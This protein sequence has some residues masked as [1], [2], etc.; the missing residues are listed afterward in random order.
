MK[1][2]EMSKVVLEN[3]GGLENIKFVERCATRLRIHFFKKSKVDLE[4]I[5]KAEGVMGVVEKG[6]QIQLIIGPTV[7]EAYTDFLEVSGFKLSGNESPVSDDN[8]EEEKNFSYY[9]NAFGSFAAGVFMPIIP[10]LVTGGLILSI[11]N[12]LVNYMGFGVDSGTAQIM[13]AIFSAGFSMLP[14]WIGYTLSSKLKM[15]PIMGAFLGAVLVSGS[16][17]GVEGLDFFGISVPAVAYESSVMPIV[18]GVVFMYFVNKLLV[19]IIPDMV[20]FFLK[21]LLT[22]AIVVPV[23]LIVLGPIGTEL[24]GAVGNFME[25]FMGV[26]GWLAVPVIA[27][28]YPYMVMLGL[29]KAITVIMIESIATTGADNW[30]LV[31]GLVSNLC[32]GAA[33]L[34]VALHVRDR[35]QKGL[36]ASFGVTALCG[37][38]EP[39][40]YGSLIM[41]PKCLVGVATGAIAGGL[42]AGIFG[43][44]NYVVGGC[45]GLL[46]ALFFLPEDGSMGNFILFWIVCAISIVVSFVAT[47]FILK[48]MNKVS[49]TEIDMVGETETVTA[50]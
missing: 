24:S 36:V 26:A 23:T 22:M 33:A 28:L 10:A 42:V 29:D 46:T 4:A 48:R 13:L 34:A 30:V 11:K 41:R 35:K 49:E 7:Q 27:A 21:P 17:S 40:F 3:V 15:E 31:T 43:L 8:E 37:V 39:A 47:T 45:P 16:I 25:A 14:V 18:F 12:L 19:K 38:T 2:I 50:K 5:K 32:I 44:Q 20:V 9:V 6:G 1:Y